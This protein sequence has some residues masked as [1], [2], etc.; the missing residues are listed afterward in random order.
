MGVGGYGHG[1]G[2]SVLFF[3][4]MFLYVPEKQTK[5]TK[6][7]SPSISTIMVFTGGATLFGHITVATA[8]IFSASYTVHGL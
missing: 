4:F 3:S 1:S 6:I 2:L 7:W 8:L 5:N